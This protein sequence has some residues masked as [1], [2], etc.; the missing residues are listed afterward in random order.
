MHFSLLYKQSPV[1]YFPLLQSSHVDFGKTVFKLV[2]L[3][4][5][6][7]MKK[8]SWLLVCC[9]LM[10]LYS[11]QSPSLAFAHGGMYTATITMAVNSR[12]RLNSWH[13]TT[14]NSTSD[15]Q[16]FDNTA[17]LL[18][19]SLLIYTHKPPPR[20]LPDSDE[21]QS[22]RQQVSPC[23]WVV[24]SG[25]LSISHVSVKT[26]TQQSLVSCCVDRLRWIKSSLFSRERTFESMSDGIAGLVGLALNLARIPPRLPR[27]CPLSHCRHRSF[28]LVA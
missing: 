3:K 8:P 18:H 6:A 10:E 2:W 21:S 27:F 19:H 1:C 22:T 13:F 23:S 20:V 14:I 17:T 25:M 28:V 26:N 4:S 16:C 9:S 12:G 5:L 15:E 11:S 7:M 24:E